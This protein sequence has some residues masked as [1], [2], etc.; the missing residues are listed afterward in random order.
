MPDPIIRRRRPVADPTDSPAN[1]RLWTD[2]FAR[3]RIGA[4]D[5]DW[6]FAI[7]FAFAVGVSVWFGR[8]IRD[9]FS[10][11]AA[12][13]LVPAFAGQT[14]IDALTEAGRLK[15]KAVVV[16]EQ[17]SD[18]YP[19]DVVMSQQP[20][21]GSRVREGRQISLIISR[22]ATISAMPDVRFESL[23]EAGLDLAHVKL[24][25]AK[26]TLVANDDI[27]A[28]HIVEQNPPP[29]TAVREGTQVTLTLSK[30]PPNGIKVP[31][32]IGD[33]VDFARR[34]ATREKVH[35]GQIVWTPFGPN[36]PPRGRI[37]RQ[38]PA[39]GTTIDPFDTVSLQVSAGPKEYGYLVRQVHVTATVPARDSAA[40]VRMEVR[41]ETGTWNVY[42]GYAQ[43]GAKLDFNLTVVGT[44]E[45]DTYINN[46]LLNQ[47]K[48]GNDEPSVTVSSKPDKK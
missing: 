47:A 16:A 30:G 21:P 20:I 15:L 45:L 1:S 12:N 32:F 5:R 7:A 25:L 36:G 24:Q 31:D 19:K 35:L 37:V 27:P 33:D 26:T 29:N 6:L 28:N 9:F 18:R 42:N 40:N 8:S 34:E 23:R 3:L 17:P 2:R 38:T 46:E 22:G 14:Q 39:A 13:V 41:D 11:A 44:A 48:L 10:P 4:I 43:G